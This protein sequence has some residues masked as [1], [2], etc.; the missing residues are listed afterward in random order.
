MYHLCFAVKIFE[1]RK[2]EVHE[3]CFA[4]KK[5]NKFQGQGRPRLCSSRMRILLGYTNTVYSIIL[6]IF[7]LVKATLIK[8]QFD[9]S[10]NFL[11]RSNRSHFECVSPCVCAVH[12]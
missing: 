3:L 9:L 1:G 8:G 11:G 4:V 12:K 10:S 6:D 2:Y 5:N 7:K